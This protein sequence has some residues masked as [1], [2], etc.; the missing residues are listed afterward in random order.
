[1]QLPINQ[2]KV[3]DQRNYIE[4]GFFSSS[5]SLRLDVLVYYL[6]IIINNVPACTQLNLF[7]QIKC[8]SQLSYEES[9]IEMHENPVRFKNLVQERYM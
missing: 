4:P 2:F 7:F 8:V 6:V 9:R 3:P 5:L 1:M